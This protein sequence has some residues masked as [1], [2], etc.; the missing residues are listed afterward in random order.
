MMHH[1][2]FTEKKVDNSSLLLT[3]FVNNT[4]NSPGEYIQDTIIRNVHGISK[5]L[6]VEIVSDGQNY[7]FESSVICVKNECRRNFVV[8]Y[9]TNFYFLVAEN[10][11]SFDD[12]VKI[13]QKAKSYNPL[14]FFL[15]YLQTKK[16]NQ[17]SIVDKI[18]SKLWNNFMA[19]VVILVAEN[20]TVFNM[21]QHSFYTEGPEHWC[22]SNTTVFIMDR[23]V[24]G[25]ILQCK[26][27][28]NEI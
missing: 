4:L 9:K 14:A 27:F 8:E 17:K 2:R 26:H 7:D 3:I 19:Y 28:S 1:F 22:G 10:D 21:Y 15:I 20:Q 5:W 13:L 12:V 6:N 11:E 24:K 18:F 23:C 16:S 25:M